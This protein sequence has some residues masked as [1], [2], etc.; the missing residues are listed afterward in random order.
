[1]PNHVCHGA[2][3]KCPMAVPPGTSSMVVMPLH[4]C[5][6]SNVPAANINDHLPFVNILPFGMCQSPSNPMF[7]AATAAALGTPTPVPCIPMTMAP[8]VV[9]SPTVMLDN[10]PALNK[11]STLLCNW[12]GVITIQME[13]QVTHQI[14]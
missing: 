10:M 3:L 7:I 14:P 5:M 12:A 1:M 9:G 8:W 2:L 4:M 6:T 13:G 11:S